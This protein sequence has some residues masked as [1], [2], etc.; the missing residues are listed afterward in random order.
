VGI[1]PQNLQTTTTASVAQVL[2]EEVARP[3]QATLPVTG[4]RSYVLLMVGLGSILIGF[5]AM[6]TAR[7]QA[8]QRS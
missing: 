5:G 8:A 6:Q 3:Q 7:R 4:S 2:G 1:L